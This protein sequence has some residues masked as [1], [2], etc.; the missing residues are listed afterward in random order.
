[1][2]DILIKRLKGT[3]FNSFNLSTAQKTFAAIELEV[4]ENFSYRTQMF[5]MYIIQKFR[6]LNIFFIFLH[7]KNMFYNI[8]SFWH[9]LLNNH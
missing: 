8:F 1:M 9:N 4:L 6:N 7:F 3:I 5:R 2:P